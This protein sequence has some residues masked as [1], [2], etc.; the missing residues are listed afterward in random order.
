VD[1]TDNKLVGVR[2]TD[3]GKSGKPN[4]VTQKGLQNDFVTTE[5]CRKENA[6]ARAGWKMNF[7]LTSSDGLR[8]SNVS[9]N[10]QPVLKSAKLVD[11]HVSYS[12][13]DGFGYS[14]AVGCPVFSQA[15]VVAF[16][17]P[18]LQDIQ[19]AGAV[20][21]FS[22]TQ[23][24]FS[25]L[26]PAPCNYF[27][28][29][30]YEFYNDGRFRPV[31]INLGRGCGND[32]TYRP[33]FRLAMAEMGTFAHWDSASNAWKDWPQEQWQSQ[34]DGKPDGKGD[35]Y[36]IKTNTNGT[37]GTNGGY[38]LEPNTGQFGD[39]SRG[40]NALIFVTKQH[41]DKDEGESDLIT[42]GPCCNT[43][44]RQGPEKYI[45][46]TPENIAASPLVIWYVPQIKND[47]TPG[48]QYCWA[49]SVLEAGVYVAKTYPCATGPMFKPIK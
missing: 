42:I 13:K 26:W 1:L 10:G 25:D 27:Y 22:I 24:F 20:V 18:A 33:V 29:Q 46:A 43:D 44:F 41:A 39:G 34:T 23:D 37:N 7:M 8:L 32:G 38:T 21:G 47:D 45:D 4:V 31:A 9:F 14:D 12:R 11:W 19:Q 28:Q 6:L 5:Y 49:D 3:L 30:R 40:D 48:K 35:Q 15:A 16:G 36:R 2:W 17:G